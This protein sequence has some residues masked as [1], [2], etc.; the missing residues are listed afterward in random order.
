MEFTLEPKPDARDAVRPGYKDIQPKQIRIIRATFRPRPKQFDAL[1]VLQ[2]VEARDTSSKRGYD[3][4]LQRTGGEL[5]CF[6]QFAI[7]YL[8]FVMLD[9]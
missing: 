7:C 8:L 2:K 1:L 5:D 4:R 3:F 9:R 6:A